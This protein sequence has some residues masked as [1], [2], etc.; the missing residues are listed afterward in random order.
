MKKTVKIILI[1]F[2]VL[3]ILGI[4]AVGVAGGLI[5]KEFSPVATKENEQIV[6]FKIPYG[7]YAYDI[8]KQLEDENLIRNRKIFYTLIRKPKYLHFIYPDIDF[9][10][11]LEFKCGI[12]N[13]SNSMNYGE[14]IEMLATGK[15][16]EIKISIPEGLTITKVGKLLE[17]SD[18]CS[19]D[20]FISV[21]HDEAFLQT[22]GIEASSAEGFLFP[23]TYYFD[24]SMNAKLVVTRLVGNFFDHINTI[25]G[26]ENKS[27]K[28]IFNI[29]KLASIVEREYK[30]DDEAPLI[31]SVFNN[32]LKIDMGLQSCATVEYIITEI[33]GKPHPERIF[34][35]DLKIDNPYNT[36]MWRGLPPGPI[37][38]P[39]VT[40]LSA[41]ANPPKTNYYFFQVVD[42]SAGRHVFTSTFKDHRDNH[43]LLTK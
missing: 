28:E 9:P 38:N 13:I 1:T 36:Y 2:L 16:E 33:Q 15:K 25:E 10:E 18:V 34:N 41:A 31:A 8:I 26:F 7:T 19:K 4:I 11:Q 17:E 37:S 35:S 27:F 43:I 39:G 42:P 40:A 21:C 5:A 32:R 20:D 3:F 12:Y 23:D 29:V 6:K 22:L 14:I 30:V 24:F